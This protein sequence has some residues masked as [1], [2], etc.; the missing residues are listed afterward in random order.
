MIRSEIRMT[1]KQKEDLYI[2]WDVTSSRL[3][4]QIRQQYKEQYGDGQSLEHWEEYLVDVLN[5][6]QSWESNGLA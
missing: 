4:E 3:K 5:L 1:D 2:E 6:R